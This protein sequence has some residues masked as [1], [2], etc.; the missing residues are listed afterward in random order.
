MRR[1]QIAPPKTSRS[2]ADQA[3]WRSAGARARRRRSP[4]VVHDIQ[5]VAVRP[6]NQR[7]VAIEPDP[8]AVV[9]WAGQA[10]MPIVAHDIGPEPP[11]QVFTLAPVTVTI[12]TRHGDVAPRRD[13]IEADARTDKQVET[14]VGL[15]PLK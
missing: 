9:W 8:P 11:R 7:D 10:V 4:K 6:V 13:E 5:D 3:A 2:L 1:G 14:T 15:T 12:L